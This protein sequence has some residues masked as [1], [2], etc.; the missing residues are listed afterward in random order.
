MSNNHTDESSLLAAPLAVVRSQ[1]QRSLRTM[2]VGPDAEARD[3]SA[4]RRDPGLF[5]PESATWIVHADAAMLIGG[6]RALLLQ[7]LHP[8]AM[9]GIADHSAYRSDPTGRLHRTAGYVGTTTFGTAAEAKAAVR[10]VRRVH[11]SVVGTAPDGRPYAANDPHLLAWVHHTLVESFYLAHQRFG[12]SS[13]S[14]TDADR[15]VDEQAILAKLIG[16]EPVARSVQQLKDAMAGIRPELK[17]GSEARNAVRFLLFP[18]LALQILP[19]YGVLASAAVGL[20]PPW[21]RRELR[22]PR[23]P[24]TERFAVRPA[25]KILTQTLGW[26]MSAP[27]A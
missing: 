21:A 24:V 14:T 18:P 13:L 22:I 27:A 9:A 7:T 20:L 17:A 10:M 5:G 6:I 1:L 23:L 25:A 4:E 15:Y 2:I 19:V 8:L 16:A 26:A 12:S 11:K 3:L